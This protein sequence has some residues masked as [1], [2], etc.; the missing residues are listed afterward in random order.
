MPRGVFGACSGVA[1]WFG[2]V[3]GPVGS[4]GVCVCG[5]ACC[6]LKQLAVLTVHELCS[7]PQECAG[8]GSE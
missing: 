4:E 1:L 8:Q 3:L 7:R 5:G 6:Q 2:E